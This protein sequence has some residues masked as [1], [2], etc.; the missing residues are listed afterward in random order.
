MKG[1]E[2]FTRHLDERARR[3]IKPQAQWAIVTAVDWGA[4]TMIVKSVLDDLE[5]YD[6]LLGLNDFYIRPEIG[7]K[8]ILGVLEGKSSTFLIYAE[9]VE[10]Y[11]WN[12]GTTHLNLSKEGFIIE[13]SD[14]NLKV[15]LNDMIDE[16]NKIKVIYGNTINVGNMNAIKQRLNSILK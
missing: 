4:K 6:V 15:V 10:E 5:Y 14:E 8:C 3:M 7:S 9:K 16:I 11:E 13:R 12:S 1:L 2:K